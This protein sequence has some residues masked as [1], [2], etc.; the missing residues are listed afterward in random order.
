[1]RIHRTLL[2]GA[3]LFASGIS[4]ASA[5]VSYAPSAADRA[6]KQALPPN[7]RAL[8]YVYRP[9]D[10]GPE[11]SPVLTLNNYPIGRLA[12]GS[13]YYW[14]VPTGNVEL[15]TEGRVARRLSLRS[16]AGRI[17]FVRLT[18]GRG[19]EIELRQV[20]YGAGRTDVQRA[21]LL[22][23]TPPSA[24]KRESAKPRPSAK[25]S[26]YEPESEPTAPGGVNLIL[27]G[28]SFSLGSKSQNVTAGPTVFAVD[29]N[30]SATIFGVEGEWVF[31]NGWAAGGEILSQ[32]H[33]YT[34]LPLS[35]TGKGD[36][37]STKFLVNGKK[38]FRVDQVVRPYVGAGLG[39]AVVN[40][41]GDISGTG[42]GYA[43]Q[44]MGGVLFQW[45]T[46]GIY[47]EAAYQKAESEGVDSGG[48]AI[49]AGLNLHF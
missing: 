39:V 28:G 18:T 44:G 24:E 14:S 46:V 48:L 41:S 34:N 22:V 16:E 49:F 35:P 42:A 27:K 31:G 33:S 38:Y 12:K 21:H 15:A 23:A 9:A 17:Y 19:G 1:M 29:F 8:L 45:R 26:T 5:A 36:M 47:T 20:S 32:H 43:V 6:A 30:S 11:E 7:G 37:T 3:C 40:M 2:L 10:G 4:T 25:A 13:F